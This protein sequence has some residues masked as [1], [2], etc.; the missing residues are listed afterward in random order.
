MGS[1]LVN[2]QR[3]RL[4]KFSVVQI[5]NK[6]LLLHFLFLTVLNC[7]ALDQ[8]RACMMS[9]AVR[10]DRYSYSP[11]ILGS[12]AVCETSAF[13]SLMNSVATV[14]LQTSL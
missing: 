8:A 13:I 10:A 14:E 2:M 3:G 1:L 7:F 11:V 9:P 4:D 6:K 12:A 5:S